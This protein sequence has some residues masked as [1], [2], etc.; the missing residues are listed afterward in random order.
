MKVYDIE[1]HGITRA[2]RGLARSYGSPIDKMHHRAIALAPLDKGHNKFLRQ[3][4]VWCEVEA[5][6]FWWPEFDQYKI[7]VVSQSDSTMHTLHKQPL[8]QEN[9]EY[10]I[11]GQYLEYLNTSINDLKAGIIT[12]DSLKNDLPEGFLQGR[13]LTFNYAVLR[14]ITLQRYN[15]KLPQ[16]QFFLRELLTSV[17]DIELLGL[18]EKVLA[19]LEIFL[20]PTC[21]K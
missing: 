2:L 9:F 21:K 19:H 13:T 16:W 14:E 11:P 17:P 20:F 18:P 12:I 7:G 4:H 10:P 1:V 15:H 3:I 5:P 6:R 8:T